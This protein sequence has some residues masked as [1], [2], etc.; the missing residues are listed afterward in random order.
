MA[1]VYSNRLSEYTHENGGRVLLLFLLFLLA[2]YELTT[3]GFT[4]FAIICCIP[5]LI[6]LTYCVFRW[7]MMAFWLLIT[8]NYLGTMKN[9]SLPIF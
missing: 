3:V 4:A 9:L 2:L 5:L 7:K 8:I 6:L 1:R